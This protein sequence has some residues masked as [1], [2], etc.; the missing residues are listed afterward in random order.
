MSSPGSRRRRTEDV[1]DD[2]GSGDTLKRVGGQAHCAEK[3][4]AGGDG[5]AS[6]RGHRI[7][8]EVAGQRDDVAARSGQV[9]R[10]EKE[11]VVDGE[12]AR[13][14]CGVGDHELPERHI[15][16][17]GGEGVVGYASRLETFQPHL[18]RRVQVRATAAV[19]GSFS[20]PTIWALGGANPMKVPAPQPGSSTR[21]PVNPASCTAFHMA[22]AMAGSKLRMLASAALYS[23]GVS[24]RFEVLALGGEGV[25]GGHRTDR[26]P[27]PTLTTA[28]E[29]PARGVACR[30]SA[31]KS[32]R[33]RSMT[34]MLASIR[35]LAP[36]GTRTAVSRTKSVAATPRCRASRRPRPPS[37]RAWRRG[38]PRSAIPRRPQRWF[39]WGDHR[40]RWW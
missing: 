38:R 4:R 30:P 15:S 8:G 12:P 33:N 7:H 40:Q 29:L 9:H 6:P 1:G 21:P 39:Q 28:P 3:L 26:V 2:A 32:W 23:V 16:D 13:A 17:G 31:C 22:A 10:F 19:I 11:C 24:T 27:P 36:D 5:L 37:A 18:R 25:A 35:A 34:A 14:V 20:T